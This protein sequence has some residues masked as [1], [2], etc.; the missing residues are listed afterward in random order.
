MRVLVADPQ[1]ER[2]IIIEKILSTFGYFRVCP[3]ASFREL[4][5][6]THYSPSLYDRFDLLILNA[7]LVSSAGLNALDF[8]LNNPRL[9]HVII[10]GSPCEQGDS[11]TLSDQAHHQVRR[12]DTISYDALA[13]FLS[14]IDKNF[15]G[16]RYTSNPH[17]FCLKANADGLSHSR[18]SMRATPSPPKKISRYTTQ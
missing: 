5:V 6:L 9:R 11:K 15:N 2:S 14:L 3:V 8:C 7:E 17:P 12:V 10:H 1:C 13:D 4:T 18:H 16:K